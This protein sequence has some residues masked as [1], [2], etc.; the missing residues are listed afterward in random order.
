MR[1][2]A[3]FVLLVPLALAVAAPARAASLPFTGTLTIRVA[4]Q[5]ALAIPGSGIASVNGSGPA[6][7]LTALALP[8]SP[9]AT[10]GAVAD[11][12]DPGVFPL[13]GLMVTAHN[14][15]GTL[16]G[17]GGAGFGGVMPLYG[18]AKVCLYGDC[19]AT[20]N[21]SNLSIPLAV[22]GKGGFIGV[23]GAINVT[24]VGAP[25]TTGTAAVGTLTAT[26][27]VAPLS[28]T[29]ATS[30][31]ITLVSPFYVLSGIG[32]FSL[33]PGMATLT[34]HF[35]PEPGTLALLGAGVAALVLTGRRARR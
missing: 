28:N 4:S 14:E 5:I 31:T 34:L 2:H 29:G 24:T 21:I 32:A 1:R 15:A 22:V 3:I 19:G 25:W 11:I 23:V 18:A 35:V 7:H 26:G 12:D 9:W 6:G 10:T 20:N 33:V 27:G 17:V 13:E 8:S 16:T 30:G